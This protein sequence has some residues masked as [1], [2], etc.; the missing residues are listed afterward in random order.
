MWG[1]KAERLSLRDS[2]YTW[3]SR[4]FYAFICNKLYYKTWENAFNL[5]VTARNNLFDK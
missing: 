3:Y 2:Y 5:Y 4:W 1:H